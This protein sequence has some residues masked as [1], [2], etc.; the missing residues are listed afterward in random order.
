[1]AAATAATA[2]FKTAMSEETGRIQALIQTK[3]KTFSGFAL[4]ETKETDYSTAEGE[5]PRSIRY[6]KARMTHEDYSEFLVTGNELRDFNTASCDGDETTLEALADK[7]VNPVDTSGTTVHLG[8]DEFTRTPKRTA[9][10]SEIIDILSVL[11]KKNPGQYIVALRDALVDSALERYERTVVK[12]LAREAYHKT[13]VTKAFRSTEGGAFF[14]AVPEGV[15]SIGTLERLA[16]RLY[17][18]NYAEGVDTPM[19]EG[20]KLIRVYAGRTQVEQ[21]IENRKKAKGYIHMSEIYANDPKFGETKVFGD[22]QFIVNQLP[23]RGF[24]KQIQGGAD[25]LYEF[26]EVYPTRNIIATGEGILEVPNNDYYDCNTVCD[27]KKEKLYEMGFITHPDALER[28]RFEVPILDKMFSALGA[29]Y[30]GFN[31][32]F[33]NESLLF[34]DVKADGTRHHVYNEDRLKAKMKINHAYA[35]FSMHPEKM[36]AF[37]VQASPDFVEVFEANCDECPEADVVSIGV[38]DQ[39]GVESTDGEWNT[40]DNPVQRAFV[41]SGPGVIQMDNCAV[42]CTKTAEGLWAQNLIIAVRRSEGYEGVATVQVDTSN[43]TATAGVN[44]TAVVATVLTFADG[45]GGVQFVAVPI[46]EDVT[47]EG[48][49]FNVTLSAVTTSSLPA[50]PPTDGCVTT[51][52][53]LEEAV[54]ASDS[55][56]ASC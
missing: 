20:R 11:Q 44:Y 49:D 41:G 19:I 35:P 2:K 52:V 23:P 13:S 21:A 47:N 16:D 3:L 4:K 53:T 48:K 54:E 17:A 28:Q 38:T 25:P 6:R 29:K 18:W 43:G 50:A 5:N 31:V 10:E 33:L 42:T 22:F 24:L 32:R 46:L 27:G 45:C 12:D 26:T 1:M 30:S 34:G 7:T 36:A 37:L 9:I 8:Y 15:L 51:V 14:N 39:P 56:C 40:D 55:A